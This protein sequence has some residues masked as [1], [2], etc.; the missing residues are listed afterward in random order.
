MT[1]WTCKQL[2][3]TNLEWARADTEVEEAMKMFG[4]DKRMAKILK[5]VYVYGGKVLDGH[6]LWEATQT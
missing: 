1:V 6:L 4:R 2:P 5:V 3:H